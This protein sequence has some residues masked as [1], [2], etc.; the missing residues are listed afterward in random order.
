MDGLIDFVLRLFLPLGLD[1]GGTGV[2]PFCEF[3]TRS[4]VP[5]WPPDRSNLPT[6]R[7][8]S[9]VQAQYSIYTNDS[10]LKYITILIGLLSLGFVRVS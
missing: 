10:F 2:P 1:Q 6:V 9:T 3:W 7:V 8:P 5:C 4:H